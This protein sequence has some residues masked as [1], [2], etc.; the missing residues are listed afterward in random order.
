MNVSRARDRHAATW[1]I[2]T[3]TAKSG[4]PASALGDLDPSAPCWIDET[5]I[6][7]VGD[8][9]S[10]KELQAVFLFHHTFAEGLS[11]LFEANSVNS[12]N[13]GSPAAP[14][15][16][17]IPIPAPYFTG[18]GCHAWI[19]LL[20]LLPNAGDRTYRYVSISNVLDANDRSVAIGE[21]WIAGVWQALSPSSIR[22]DYERPEAQLVTRH[23]SKRG[24]QTVY[25][26]GSRVRRLEA[27]VQFTSQ[28]GRDQILDWFD[29]AHGTARPSV[30]VLDDQSG[31]RRS[32]EP[33]LVRFDS[34][35][36]TPASVVHDETYSLRLSFEELGA[37]E[38]IPA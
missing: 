26:L 18:F 20:E 34:T 5:A 32:A 29:D 25:D 30:I 37:G 3:G 9:G 23:Q 24:V 31:N 16:Q 7:L 17:L 19:N 13:G 6:T 36:I 27:Q 38:P 21:I 28:A 2:Q 10:A 1:T 14:L 12:F 22:H 15:S 8:L 33:H 11:V 4:Y 35:P